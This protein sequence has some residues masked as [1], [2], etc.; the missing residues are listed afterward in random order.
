MNAKVWTLKNVLKN[1]AIKSA[2]IT[3][4][5]KGAKVRAEPRAIRTADL[6]VSATQSCCCR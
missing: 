3:T 6:D 5:M 4:K 2:T 1:S